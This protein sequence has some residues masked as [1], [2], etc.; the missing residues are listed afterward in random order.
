M[1]V[2][3]VSQ[4][5]PRILLAGIMLALAGGA[6]AAEDTSKGAEP[7]KPA[8]EQMAKMHDEMAACLRSDKSFADCRTQMH[9]RCV[10]VM[11]G[12]G[13]PM[14]G[15]GMGMQHPPRESTSPDRQ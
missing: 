11:H 1:N 8:R 3:Y 13:C 7:S 5:G 6:L 2:R 14:M 9:E 12:Q 15:N 4:M 10:A